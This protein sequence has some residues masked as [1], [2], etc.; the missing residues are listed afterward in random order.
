MKK[1]FLV[2]I[3]LVLVS[4]VEENKSQT[5]RLEGFVFGTTY[6]ITYLSK[7]NTNYQKSIDSLFYLV[8]KSLSTYIPTSDIS[9]INAGNLKKIMGKH[10]RFYVVLN[11]C[12]DVTIGHRINLYFCEM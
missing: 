11:F 4:C 9:K 10:N 8:N 1:L 6:H 12:I 2:G 3:F 5:T 7:D